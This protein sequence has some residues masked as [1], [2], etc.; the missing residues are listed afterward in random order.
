MNAKIDSFGRCPKCGADWLHVVD[1]RSY[2]RIIGCVDR[3]TDRVEHW[4]CP[5][6]GHRWA[7]G[8]LMPSSE[9]R[10]PDVP[11]MAVEPMPDF[12]ADDPLAE[13]ILAALDPLGDG[14]HA[15]RLAGSV[16]AV[17]AAVV[18]EYGGTPDDFREWIRDGV[19]C[20]PVGEADAVTDQ[21]REA[22]G[23]VPCGCHRCND[24]R[25]KANGAPLW[26]LQVRGMIVCPDCGN[27]RCSHASDH[28]LTCSGSNDAGQA[29]S[30]YQ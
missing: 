13:V 21:I 17:R 24:E 8:S 11:Q 27:K 28:R 18:A 14:D 5:D 7:R 10:P 6:C 30:V 25:W 26:D 2:S 3:A 4:Q 9:T 16:V 20:L 19:M 22:L 29:G 12:P 23:A 15:Y 1:G